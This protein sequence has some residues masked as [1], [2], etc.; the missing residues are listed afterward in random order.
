MNNTPDLLNDPVTFVLRK[1]TVPMIL[2]M[3]AMMTFS[4]VD[5]FFVAQLG[6]NQLAAVSFTFPVT[7]FVISIAIG[8]GIGTSAVVAKCKGA[9]KVEMV[10]RYA[11]DAISLGLVVVVF[12]CIL[13]LNTI[14]PL[15]S[16]MGATAETMPF[17][18]DY[19][20][21]WYYGVVF[22]VVPMTLNSSLRAL[23][24]TSLPSI[25]MALAGLFNVIL[26]YFLI[27][28]H[29]PFPAMGVEGAALATVLAWGLSLLFVCANKMVREHLISFDRPSL[30]QI[31][32]SWNIILKIALPA[33]ASNVLTPLSSGIITAMIATLGAEY[34]AAF[35][36]GSRIE[37]LCMIVI[38][39]LSMTLPPFVSQ[40]H[41]ANNDARV[42]AGI[43]A[44]L[45][46]TIVWQFTVYLGLTLLSGPISH[47]FSD[48]S[49]VQGS[50]QQFILIVTLAYGCQGAI[51]LINSSL[52][53]LHLP[54][55][56]VILSVIRLFCIQIPFAY[57]GM[58]LNGFQGALVGI[59]VGI[60]TM[61]LISILWMKSV[62]K[63][64]L[65][66][67]KTA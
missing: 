45:L 32:V 23:G 61:S 53:A 62:N 46:F 5:T 1:M 43:K 49:N 29:G 44:A 39:A 52:N 18:I 9:G 47:L 10:K 22:I 12:V 17:I 27:F 54:L 4:L 3:I 57:A 41:G 59:A 50:I 35:G 51:I 28:G 6:T 11:T 7:F 14:E 66:K 26:D 63:K 48:D 34:V 36:V 40:N 33:T 30:A 24:N 67:K 31:W 8:L 64:H 25:G 58:Y 60:V 21:I 20:S 42:K 55:D 38:L 19:M 16:A 15:F 13:G 56:A 37:S 2:G 65:S